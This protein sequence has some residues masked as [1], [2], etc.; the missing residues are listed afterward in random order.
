[1][2][3]FLGTLFCPLL[4]RKEINMNTFSGHLCQKPL[5]DALIRQYGRG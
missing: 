2:C 4:L 1:M 3:A 5:F